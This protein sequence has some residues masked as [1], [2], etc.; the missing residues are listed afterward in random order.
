MIAKIILPVV[1]VFMFSCYVPQHASETSAYTIGV[2]RDSHGTGCCKWLIELPAPPG[3][4]PVRF[5]PIN[6]EEF[7][8]NP[9]EGAQI[10]F[11]YEPLNTASCCMVGTVIRL[12]EAY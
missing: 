1:V 10:K 7:I 11:T 8:L 6:L 4:Q 12:K 3:E 9:S 2:L 5:N